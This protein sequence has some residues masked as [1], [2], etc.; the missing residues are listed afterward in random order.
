MGRRINDI[1]ISLNNKRNLDGNI[2]IHFYEYEKDL[3][4]Y[5]QWNLLEGT[6]YYKDTGLVQYL[7]LNKGTT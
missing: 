5:G 1:L 6:V 3:I 7:I 4:V 2:L